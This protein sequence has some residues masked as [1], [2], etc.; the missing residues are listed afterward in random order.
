MKKQVFLNIAKVGENMIG[1]KIPP[2]RGVGESRPVRK[3]GTSV[4]QYRTQCHTSGAQ[5]G[6][7][8]RYPHQHRTSAQIMDS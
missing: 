1:L 8:Q 6:G 4:S 5:M 3:A 2:S 7:K